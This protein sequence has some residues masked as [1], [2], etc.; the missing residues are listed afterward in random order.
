MMRYNWSKVLDRFFKI[1]V[2]LNVLS[3]H[4]QVRFSDEK[5]FLLWNDGPVR[6]WRKKSQ[7]YE[8]GFVWGTVK[9]RTGIMVW[10]CIAADGT[11]RL[12]RC[13]DRQD[14]VSYQTRILTPAL[15]FI[16]AG[17]AT[18]RH[19]VV[20]Q[21]D[22]ASS[23]TSVSTVRFLADKNVNVLPNW[24]P[25]S[26]DLNLVEH[27]WAYISKQLLGKA[28]PTSDA[29]WAAINDA[30]DR[31]P[32]ELIPALYGSMVRR[33]TAVQVAKGGPTKY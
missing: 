11:S 15:S 29:L 25:N 2:G 4:P 24:P 7:K 12:L 8:Q 22:G 28:Y 33:L 21:Q 10:L 31:R 3:T 14:S 27:C 23:H 32:P 13:D 19:S 30:W 16:K 5:R 20:F 26:P 17:R 1:V 9:N 18:D 6:V